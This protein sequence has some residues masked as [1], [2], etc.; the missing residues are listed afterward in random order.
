MGNL[1]NPIMGGCSSKTKEVPKETEQPAKVEDIDYSN[2]S[3]K[4][5]KTLLNERGIDSSKCIEKADLIKCLEVSAQLP[6]GKSTTNPEPKVA[7]F[8]PAQVSS[9]QQA[10]SKL[11]ALLNRR[12]QSDAWNNAGYIVDLIDKASSRRPQMLVAAFGSLPILTSHLGR[13]QSEIQEISSRGRSEKNLVRC[14]T[15]DLNFNAT[16]KTLEEALNNLPPT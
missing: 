11:E 1:K 7:K 15:S 6:K 16:C 10:C 14:L 13:L 3:S 12:D 5:L 4:Q 8:T 9:V 2:M